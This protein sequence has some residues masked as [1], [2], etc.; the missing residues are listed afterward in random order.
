[1]IITKLANN[2]IEITGV[3]SP[4]TLQPSMHTFRDESVIDGANVLSDGDVIDSFSSANIEKL[5]RKDGTEILT[6]TGDVLYSELKDYFFFLPSGS[7]SDGWEVYFPDTD[8]LSTGVLKT[9]N[10]VNFVAADKGY[11]DL[12]HGSS[13]VTLTGDFKL[14]CI[15]NNTNS[16]FV[17]GQ[18]AFST[19]FLIVAPTSVS[20]RSGNSTSLTFSVASTIDDLIEVKKNSANSSFDLFKN[21]SLVD[22]QQIGAHT[23]DFKVA[24]LGRFL[25]T[26]STFQLRYARFQN[27]DGSIDSEYLCTGGEGTRFYDSNNINHGTFTNDAGSDPTWLT[28]L[29]TPFN[30][31]TVPTLINGVIVNPLMTQTSMMS[32]NL[33]DIDGVTLNPEGVVCIPEDK[34]NLGFDLNNN[35]ITKPYFTNALNLTGQ[36]NHHFNSNV[37]VTR[38]GATTDFYWIKRYDLNRV[39]GIAADDKFKHYVDL[40]NET[41]V[42]SNGTAL[43]ST[44]SEIANEQWLF[45]P[46]VNDGLGSATIYFGTTLFATKVLVTGAV[47]AAVA[48][49]LNMYYGN[50]HALGSGFNGYLYQFGMYPTAKTL[51]ELEVIRVI[52]MSDLPIQPHNIVVD[53]LGNTGVDDLGNTLIQII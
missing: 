23:S 9:A 1:M 37:V 34:N 12:G 5:V 4:Y 17:F 51:A 16:P 50:T 40:A 48:A 21:N 19:F 25:T 39:L 13:G 53:D 15:V 14:S 26:Y 3:T 43:S 2:N 49:T 10:G 52:T 35:A 29:D 46:V 33:Y 24:Y 31:L 42:N 44:T 28:G 30:L 8:S 41:T 7:I 6:P 20:F 18:S 22:S 11:I 36:A 38:T 47:G 32:Y 27:G 45:V